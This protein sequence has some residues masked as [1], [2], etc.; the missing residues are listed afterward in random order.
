MSERGD[1]EIVRACAEAMGLDVVEVP[2]NAPEHTI[3]FR[4]TP[5]S[6]LRDYW[7]ITD[8]EQAMALGK[9]HPHEFEWSIIEWHR[10]LGRKETVSL[11]RILCERIAKRTT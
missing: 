7:P 9:A 11:N 1:L 2:N 10:A 5:A 8:D 4:Y 3:R 6:N